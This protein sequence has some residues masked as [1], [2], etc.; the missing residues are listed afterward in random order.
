MIVYDK[1]KRALKEKVSLYE[2]ISRVITIAANSIMMNLLFLVASLPVVTIGAAWNGLFSAIRYNI[3]GD[4]WF[5][6]F[7]KGFKT[8]FWRSTL[9]WIVMLPLNAIVI[10]DITAYM[11]V[12]TFTTETVVRLVAAWIMLLL[13]TGLTGAL[14]LLNVYIPTSVGNWIR[15][16]V[17]MV[18]KAPLQLAIM[19]ALM[20][21]PLMLA[22]LA[23]NYFF[24]FIMVFIVA[25]YMLI[26][27]GITMLMKQ[28]LLDYLLEAR[29][30][31]S[32]LAEE[33]KKKEENAER[34]DNDE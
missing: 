27:F 1:G 18:F 14:I 22:L 3:R 20:W 15:N 6:G 4:R 21:F 12:D 31:G 24:Y 13:T 29:A 7:K 11:S 25:Y 17:N 26:A 19:G 10:M 28:T 33:G 34:S 2:K 9:S 8:R 23:F 5:D 16:A 30:Q 32:L